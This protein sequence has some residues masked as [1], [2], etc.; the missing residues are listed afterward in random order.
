VHCFYNDDSFHLLFISM[1]HGCGVKW[2]DLSV[3]L[4]AGA[5][6]YFAAKD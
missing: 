4:V 2:L 6:K 3:S 1:P 5:E